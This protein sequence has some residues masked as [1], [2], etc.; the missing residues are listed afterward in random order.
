ME[1]FNRRYNIDTGTTW[2]RV[3]SVCSRQT[4]R[5]REQHQLFLNF[6]DIGDKEED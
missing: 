2:A 4:D 3:R 6:Q 1:C 5:E